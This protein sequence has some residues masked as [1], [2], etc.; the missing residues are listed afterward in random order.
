MIGLCTLR[1]CYW[2]RGGQTV[3][4][5]K[6]QIYGLKSNLYL[7]AAVRYK[8][9]FKNSDSFEILSE[10]LKIFKH[11]YRLSLFC[12]WRL[13]VPLIF[14]CQNFGIL[15]L[16]FSLNTKYR[17]HS[18]RPDPAGCR[19]PG[20]HTSPPPPRRSPWQIM[21]PTNSATK[22]PCPVSLAFS[23]SPWSNSRQSTC[24]PAERVLWNKFVEDWYSEYDG[25]GVQV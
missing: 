19:F 16:K 13:K 8:K 17:Y 3:H 14:Y 24:G 23:P 10:T 11:F 5:R 18:T 15:G 7:E 4:I 22:P 2:V 9:T 1:I 21:L 6:P 25:K 12:I 20:W